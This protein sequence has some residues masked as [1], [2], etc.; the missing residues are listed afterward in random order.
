MDI[1]PEENYR[2]SYRHYVSYYLYTIFLKMP[3]VHWTTSNSTSVKA[4]WERKE[5]SGLRWNLLGAD[6]N[7]YIRE[8]GKCELH[9]SCNF[10]SY[11]DTLMLRASLL[12]VVACHS[13]RKIGLYPTIALEI[14]TVICDPTNSV[15]PT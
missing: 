8:R 15:D 1:E 10:S 14:S 11:R 6:M 2:F 9:S 4:Y 7:R 12:P 3:S 13:V 5:D